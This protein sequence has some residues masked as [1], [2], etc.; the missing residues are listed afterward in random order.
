MENYHTQTPATT[1][2]GPQV[3]TE[4]HKNTLVPI[5]SLKIIQRSMIPAQYSYN[6]NSYVSN[7]IGLRKVELY[8]NHSSE[9]LA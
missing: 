9:Q 2:W 4:G 6:G 5:K 7:H 1:V 8:L 3:R